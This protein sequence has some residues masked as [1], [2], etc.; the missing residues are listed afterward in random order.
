MVAHLFVAGLNL[1][2]AALAEKRVWLAY[3]AA[4]LIV[5]SALLEAIHFELQQA[6]VY[7]L[8]VG[9]YLLAIGQLERRRLGWQ[10]TMPL[11]GTA[12]L[13]MLGTTLL[14]SFGMLGAEGQVFIYGLAL[15]AESLLV[16]AWGI[17]QRVRLTF[18]TG[19]VST[20]VAVL[21]LVGQPLLPAAAALDVEPLAAI[22][23]GLGVVIL[24]I[25]IFL[26]RQREVL[27][28]R[29]REW[30]VQIEDWD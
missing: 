4:A 13:L 26:E 18:V 8:P 6:Q 11:V 9:G 17:L 30:L 28:E 12:L 1:S 21:V 3:P 10:L 7:V 23:G 14:Q 16:I 19:I 20:F 24:A 15:L 5:S 29:G 27:L 25:A 22:F 2:I